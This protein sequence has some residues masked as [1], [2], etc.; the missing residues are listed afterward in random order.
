MNTFRTKLLVSSIGLVLSSQAMAGD[1]LHYRRTYEYD[2]LGRLIAE[3]GENGQVIRYSRDEEGRVLSV[4]DALNRQVSSVYDARGRL[5][6]RIEPGNR[7]SNY[8][9]D[10]NGRLVFVTDPKGH[11]TSYE[12]DG[13][14]LTWK[15]TS[16]D[17]G[18]TQNEYSVQG[19]LLRTTKANGDVVTYEHD[20]FGRPTRLVSGS[21]ERRF[22]YD[23]CPD[24]VGRLC[25]AELR[26]SA[27]LQNAVSRVY[28]EWGTRLATSEEG[29]TVGGQPYS[30]TTAYVHD[31][32]LRVTGVSYPSGISVGYGYSGRRIATVTA[33][34]QGVSQVVA[35]NFEYLPFDVSEGFTYGNGLERLLHYDTDGRVFGIS[36]GSSSTLVQSLTYGY[37]VADEIAAITNGSDANLTRNYLYDEMGRVADETSRNSQWRYDNNGNRTVEVEGGV[38]V[39][40]NLSST[41]NRLMS[42]GVPAGLRSFTYDGQGSRIGDA[43]PGRSVTYQYDGFNQL[44]GATV[45]GVSAA[46]SYNA[47]GQRVGKGTAEEETSFVYAGRNTVLA[48]RVGSGWTS[49]VW[50][51]GQLLAVVKPDQQLRYVHGDHLGRPE[52]VTNAIGQKVWT[53]RNDAFNRQA[54][55]DT[56]GGLNL[57][58]PGQ[59]ADAETGL[60]YNGFRYYD[61]SVGAYTQADPLGLAG[62]SFSLYSYASSNP[63]SR[64]DPLGLADWFVGAEFDWV[65][66]GGVEFSM[67]LVLDTDDVY[68]SGIFM[69]T[70]DAV[71]MNKGA[72]VMVGRTERDIEGDGKG[73]DVNA[74]KIS[75]SKLDDDQGLNGFSWSF[76]PGAGYSESQGTTDTLSLRNLG[77]GRPPIRNNPAQVR[78]DMPGDE[79]DLACIGQHCV[80]NEDPSEAPDEG[81]G[82]GGG[83][84]GGGGAELGGREITVIGGGCHGNCNPG[85]VIVGASSGGGS[86]ARVEIGVVEVK[87]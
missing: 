67:G 3:R 32:L 80:G 47:I 58:F 59:Y 11:T 27:V 83:C 87:R 68:A 20:A 23:A 17:T 8:T 85:T 33:T 1:A 62:G 51:G 38:Q 25:L 54:Q 73:N 29:L 53:A 86:P 79:E 49:Y 18:V 14:G 64:I 37:N 30:H 45:N 74:K 76:G 52:V 44:R 36:A 10:N 35:Q 65:R 61:S 15:T 21:S 41:S 26:E 9:Y 19:V 13:F 6:E 40:Y 71:G 48:E 4:K 77:F 2:D 69:S 7:T 5:V 42:H 50:L 72:G 56:I 43:A 60:W 84:E 78:V 22:I 75:F 70:A 55:Q 12:N 63:V 46:Y 81:G 28:G 16:P 57:G 34:V 39:A 24:G 31:N 66:G 82:G